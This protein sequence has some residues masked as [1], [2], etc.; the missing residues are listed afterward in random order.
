M[1][2]FEKR[3][4]ALHPERPSTGK[5]S[6]SPPVPARSSSLVIGINRTVEGALGSDGDRAVS[7]CWEAL[8]GSQ[9]AGLLPACLPGHGAS[10]LGMPGFVLG[11]WETPPP[12]QP[13]R[14]P[15]VISLFTKLSGLIFT[16][17]E[18]LPSAQL[19][20]LEQGC[21]LGSGHHFFCVEMGTRRDFILL[22]PSG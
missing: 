21:A 7:H 19:P 10:W 4:R 17:G 9:L 5:E 13:G 14:D 3:K 2:G 6:S 22:L 18:H 11:A 20:G 12:A 8:A 15:G 1:T 16:H